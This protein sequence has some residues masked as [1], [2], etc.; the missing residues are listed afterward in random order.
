MHIGQGFILLKG[1]IKIALA[2][3][4][5]QA[6]KISKKISLGFGK[7]IAFLNG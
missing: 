3:S 6:K 5:E 7:S 4:V 2:K 1:S